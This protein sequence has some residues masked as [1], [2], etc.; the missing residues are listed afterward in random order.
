MPKHIAY[1]RS[2][3]RYAD[4]KGKAVHIPGLA[5]ISWLVVPA[6]IRRDKVTLHS[7]PNGTTSDVDYHVLVDWIERGKVKV[8]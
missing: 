8:I 4:L 5:S 7:I 3:I 1:Q 2:T 6:T